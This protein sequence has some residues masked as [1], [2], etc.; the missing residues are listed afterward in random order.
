MKREKNNEPRATKDAKRANTGEWVIEDGENPPKA[1]VDGLL[2][3]GES[4]LSQT[5]EPTQIASDGDG[6]QDAGNRGTHWKRKVRVRNVAFR[7]ASSRGRFSQLPTTS[8]F[9]LFL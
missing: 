1:P 5:F 7:F 9:F 8:S 4:A 3:D 6:A 2:L